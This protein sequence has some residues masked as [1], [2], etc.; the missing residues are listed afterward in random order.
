MSALPPKADI[1]RCARRVEM[2]PRPW[3]FSGFFEMEGGPADWKQNSGEGRFQAIDP[4]RAVGL[5]QGAL[6]VACQPEVSCFGA[7]AEPTADR[8]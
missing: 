7:F 4:A 6:N 3:S 1:G 5:L 2:I 8:F